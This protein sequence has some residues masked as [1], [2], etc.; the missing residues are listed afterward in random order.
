MKQLALVALSCFLLFGCDN[1]N[2]ETSAAPT[3][4]PP[5]A[6]ETNQAPAVTPPAAEKIQNP[7]VTTE[8]SPT[9]GAG[10]RSPNVQSELAHHTFVL[11]SFDARQSPDK[12]PDGSP[13]ELPHLS[14]G[15]WPNLNGK[16]CNGFRG[17][18]QA[19]GSSL[20]MENAASTMMLCLDDLNEL[21]QA[22]HQMMKDGANVSL[23][24][25]ELTL[26]GGGHSLV[27]ILSDYVN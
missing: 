2:T 26:E 6:A 21:E 15:Q 10:E 27:F 1:R 25:R 3:P 22:F 11:K 5:A 12:N 19:Q 14:F 7:A 23:G 8:T 9:A 24:N 4:A 16:M 17:M 13:R 20:T 18:V